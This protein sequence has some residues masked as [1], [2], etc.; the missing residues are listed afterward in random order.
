M[1]KPRREGSFLLLRCGFSSTARLLL[2]LDGTTALVNGALTVGSARTVLASWNRGYGV[3]GRKKNGLTTWTRHG[4]VTEICRWNEGVRNEDGDRW[5]W[6]AEGRGPVLKGQNSIWT[7]GHACHVYRWF[8][9]MYMNKASFLKDDN[10]SLL[11]SQLK[12]YESSDFQSLAFQTFWHYRQDG[13]YCIWAL[14]V[15]L[16]QN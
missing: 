2:L 5:R 9:D 3:E 7:S 13:R 11:K 6:I 15:R 8:F 4:E 10:I 14:Q 1:G 12:E 16:A